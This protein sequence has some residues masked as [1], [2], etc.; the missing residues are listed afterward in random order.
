MPFVSEQ[1][2]SRTKNQFSPFLFFTTVVVA[3]ISSLL[4]IFHAKLNSI[5]VVGSGFTAKTVCSTLFLSGL[6]VETVTRY[7]L[8]G[9]AASLYSFHVNEQ[10]RT[11]T[12]HPVGLP[13]PG[14]TQTAYFLGKRLGCQLKNAI[15]PGDDSFIETSPQRK[16]LDRNIDAVAQ[17]FLDL[18]MTDAAFNTNHTRA[19]LVLCRG[20]VIAEAYSHSLNITK[21]TPLLGWSM[22][23][24][25]QA[26][27]IGSLLAQ[28]KALNI[29]L[30][31]ESK[32]L[33]SG[34]TLRDMLSMRDVLPGFP[35][36]Y[37]ITDS[38]PQ[39]LYESEDH[40]DFARVYRAPR[41]KSH[42]Q[43]H[44]YLPLFDENNAN[45]YQWYY[46]SGVSNVLAKEIRTYFKGNDKEYWAHPFKYVFDQIGAGTFG[47]ELDPSGTFVASSFCYASAEDWAK[48]GLLLLKKGIWDGVDI[49]PRGF[50]DS[51]TMPTAGSGGS[52]IQKQ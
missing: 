42:I 15:A 50:V 1:S 7:E 13:L 35:E 21:D 9:L 51:M 41:S 25:V 18:Q 17:T 49:L 4:W 27:T 33:Q 12:A 14:F 48:L 39:M 37:E 45:T 6:S 26:I 36:S 29:S 24:T 34:V 28:G 32:L 47:C 40:A 30:D 22:T 2:I 44:N 3:I 38:V 8:A 10:K 5:L 52:D 31:S 11:V 46:S 20:K 16:S 43:N 19:A 23:K